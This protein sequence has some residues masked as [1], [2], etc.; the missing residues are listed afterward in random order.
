MGD[1]I[2]PPASEAPAA[3]AAG[4]SG[5]KPIVP[6][7]LAASELIKRITSA[8]PDTAMPPSGHRVN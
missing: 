5:A 6:G 3:L 2:E 4:E 7:D 1:A 8:D